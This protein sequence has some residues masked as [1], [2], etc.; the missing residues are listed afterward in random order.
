VYEFI[1]WLKVAVTAVLT[2]TP[3]AALAGVTAMTVGAAAAVVK[4]QE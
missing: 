4:V 1:A 3:V 2:A